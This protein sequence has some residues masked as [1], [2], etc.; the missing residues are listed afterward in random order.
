[1]TRRQSGEQPTPARPPVSIRGRGTELRVVVERSDDAGAAQ[2]SLREQ[3]ERRASAFF[4][5]APVALVLPG[6]AVDLTL[7]ARLASEIT[8]AGMRVVSVE[9]AEPAGAPERIE[10]AS[11]SSSGVAGRGSRPRTRII[12]PRS[13]T[14]RLAAVGARP[15]ETG[16]AAAAESGSTSDPRRALEAGAAP[17][18]DRGS[19]EARPDPAIL[20]HRTLR[21]GQRVEHRGSVVV[22]GD[23]NPGA[24]VI[25]GGDVVVWGRLRG[26]VEAGTEVAGSRVCA[27][28]LAPTQLIIGRAIARAPEEPGRVPVPEVAREEGGLIVVD[29]WRP[30]S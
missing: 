19:A 26:T 29:T 9:L 10:A 11:D 28:D 8:A 16:R 2:A 24:E 30:Q 21:G 13:G 5:G 4:A 3:L 25:A 7:A 27:L 12:E 6:S 22:L 17:E 15:I 18:P 14:Q 23:V 1:M 20:V